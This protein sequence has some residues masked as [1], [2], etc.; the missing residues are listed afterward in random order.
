MRD[1]VVM[2]GVYLTIAKM[3]NK[4]DFYQDLQI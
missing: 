1:Q 4:L 2:V 3:K